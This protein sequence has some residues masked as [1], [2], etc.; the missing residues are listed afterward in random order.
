[1]WDA[2]CATSPT[3]RRPLEQELEEGPLPRPGPL[4]RLCSGATSPT[5]RRKEQQQQQ[6]G[7]LWCLA[8]PLLGDRQYTEE[9][10][11]VVVEEEEAASP[12][13]VGGG[14][15]GGK[16]VIIRGGLPKLPGVIPRVAPGQWK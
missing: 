13:Q 5:S 9:E 15:F 2:S 14:E 10:E 8:L 3:T 12:L 11:E 6:L 4:K 16:R 1:M 7:G